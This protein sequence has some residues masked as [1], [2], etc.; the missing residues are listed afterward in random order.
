MAEYQSAAIPGICS[1]S[2]CPGFGEA[3]YTLPALV[4]DATCRRRLPLCALEVLLPLPCTSA[5]DLAALF[6]RSPAGSSETNAFMQPLS[7]RRIPI[8]APR[9]HSNLISA[10]G[11]VPDTLQRLVFSRATPVTRYLSRPGPLPTHPR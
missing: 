10:R 2:R 1:P 9:V 8:A 3:A 6:A 5:S 11:P 4:T 7:L